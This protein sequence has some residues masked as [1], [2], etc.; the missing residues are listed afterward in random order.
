MLFGNEKF[1]KLRKHVGFAGLVIAVI[2]AMICL[3]F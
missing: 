3:N 1:T 2:P